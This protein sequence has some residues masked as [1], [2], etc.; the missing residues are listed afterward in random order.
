MTP[1]PIDPL[2]P[3]IVESL[4]RARSVVVVAPPGSGKTTRVPPA[5]FRAGLLT[6][7]NPALVLLQP[8][9]VAA[10][11][12]ANRIAVENGW[13]VGD[14]VG[15]QVR[16]E[17]RVGPR[18]RLRVETEGILNRQLIADPFLEGVGCVVLDEFHERSLHTDLAI[19]LLREVRETVRDDLLLVV[20]S[21]T[22]DAEPVARFLGGCPIV[23]GE[24][25]AYPVEIRYRA[26][27]K[28]ASADSIVAAVEEA[29]LGP[30]DPGHVLVFLPGAEEIRRAAVHLEPIARREGFDVLPLHG[31]L[32][33]EDQDRALQPT[34][35]RKVILATNI[36]ETSL[37]IDGVRTVI[38]SGLARFASDDP[39]RGLDRLELG[40]I[41]RASAAQRAGRAGRTSAGRC[42]RLWS[43]RAQRGL[44]ESDPP[45]VARV[46]LASTALMLHAW[47][48]TDLARF[49]W[50]E[51]P[52]QERLDAAERLLVLLGAL[53]GDRR[54]LMPLG[55][56]LLAIPAHPR[57]A[58]LLTAA[59]EAGHPREGAAIAALLSEKDIAMYERAGERF[60]GPSRSTARGSS[61]LLDRLDMLAEAER[62]RFA[63][64]LRDQGIDPLGARRVAKARDEFVRIARR[65]HGRVATVEPDDDAMLM[66]LL[67]AYP[68]RVVRRRGGEAT[69]L[70]VGGRGVRLAPESVV[71]DDEFFL[72][73]DPREDRRGAT[74]EAKVRVAS[75]VKVEWLE[76]LFPES[77]RRDR[78]VEFDQERQRAVGV[79]SLWYRDLRL[80]EDRNAKVDASEASE[81]LAATLA[82]RAGEFVRADEHAAAWLVRLEFLRRVMPESGWPEMDDESLAVVVAD[83]CPGKRTVDEVRRVPL[84]PLLKARLTHARARSMDELAPEAL[85]VPS[86]SR[87]RLVYEDGRAPVLAVRLQELFGWTETPRIAS[88]RVAVVL[89]L[90]GPN[91]RP[92]QVTDDLRSFWATTYFQVRKDLRARYP[93]HSW[94]DDPL[95]ARPE[96][97]GGRRS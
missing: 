41:S 35:R 12:A 75:A 47:G 33:A 28:P 55:R 26:A 7:E 57:I 6:P 64:R 8:R 87:I 60:G 49:P 39:A 58:R 79:T 93:R 95:T 73:L 29:L 86:G 31:A 89:H 14:E 52:P 76:E 81:A 19:A 9:R 92:A 54:K 88:G 77:L 36:A 2:L 66:W 84:V 53:G 65:L 30:D 78:S 42:I 20:M 25:R 62:Q 46:D 51:P 32:P 97:K 11:A 61:D 45:E 4:R 90:L 63:P 17:R 16:F 83:A 24:G 15:Y 44:A 22:L 21:A 13:A 5:I 69:G 71:R 48:A 27:V 70:M 10:R 37:T 72:A 74:L 43:E 82:E 18:T 40:R 96:A 67:L 34:D 50:F 56:R 94:P 85:T 38:D 68:D 23:K 80:R 1:L 91:Y 3:E 59:A